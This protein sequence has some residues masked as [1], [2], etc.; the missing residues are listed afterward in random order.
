MSEIKLPADDQQPALLTEPICL[1]VSGLVTR[2]SSTFFTSSLSRPKYS[3]YLDIRTA[4][5][6]HTTSLLRQTRNPREP[7]NS[8]RQHV[9]EIWSAQWRREDCQRSCAAAL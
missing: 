1:P 3:Q 8:Y 7:A 2:L 4:L 5:I 6:P 9:Q